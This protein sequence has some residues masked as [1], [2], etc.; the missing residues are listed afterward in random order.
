MPAAGEASTRTTTGRPTESE[1]R[2]WI[3]ECI[4]DVCGRE[5]F[6]VL[7]ARQS[8]FL[9]LFG[10]VGRTARFAD[11]YLKLCELECMS[12][13]V[14]LARVALEHAVTAQWVYIVKGGV[15]RYHRS[16]VQGQRDYYATL[17]DWLNHSELQA[18]VERLE[19][20]AEGKR[21]PPFM[22]MLRDLDIGKFLETTYHVLSQQV[23]VTHSAVTSFLGGGDDQMHPKY[24]QEYPYPYQLSY[25]VAVACMLVR[26][27]LA[28]LT[29][30][31]AL[32]AALDKKSD[33][34]ILPMNLLEG[35]PPENRRAGL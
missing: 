26:W 6:T 27:I 13:A 20:A 9:L 7:E 14:P 2:I 23:H 24:E 21:L 31:G 15:A 5:E 17:A 35:V 1:L 29:D 12:E 32:L 34:L 30:D 16:A 33:A 19:P 11:G 4:T 25:A 3:Q 10:L 18:A 22:N 8:E 28:H